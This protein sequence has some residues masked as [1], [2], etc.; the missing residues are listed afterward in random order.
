MDNK[1]VASFCDYMRNEKKSSANT[2][3]SYERDIKSFVAYIEDNGHDLLSVSKTQVISYML[4]MQKSGKAD[5]TISRCIASVRALYAYLISKG[6][7]K[8]NPAVG[9][10]L[11]K[12]E[13][14]LP[15]ILSRKEVDALLG[16]LE[17]SNPKE[18]RDKAML[19]IM[20]ASGIK[21]S[22]LVSLKV[23]DVD[24]D[25]GYL[26]CIHE[27]DVRIVPL[28]RPAV[29]AVKNYLAV[30]R[31]LMANEDERCLFVNYTGSA[32]TRQGFWKLIKEYAA[33]AGIEK[34]ITPHTLRHSFA[35]HLLENGADLVSI[36]EML[37]HKDIS[38][39]QMYAK[40]VHGRIREVYN[41][42][43]PRA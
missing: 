35:A 23:E 10:K 8:D 41:K 9:I 12:Q 21:V 7:A 26:K 6:S 2:V 31:P 28:G 17:D 36:Q 43:H 33:K 16:C 37:G 42:A 5:S 40:L 30:S 39:T 25:L 1:I 22:E 34:T 15:E 20:Y 27:T 14:K 29:M 4:S 13:R 24:T 38:S 19:E 18:I 11:P 3:I 32:M